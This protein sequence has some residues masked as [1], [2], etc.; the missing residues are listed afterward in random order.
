[1]VGQR[2]VK[3]EKVFTRK[4][5]GWVVIGFADYSGPLVFPLRFALIF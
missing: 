4:G 2:T 1:M 3:E 5:A